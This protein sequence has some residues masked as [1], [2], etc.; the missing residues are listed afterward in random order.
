MPLN[1]RSIHPDLLEARKLAYEPCAFTFNNLSWEAESLEYGACAF[2]LN[3]RHVMFRS[4][5]KTP[6][7][8]GQ[9]VT[10]WKRPVIGGPILP[11]DV[12]DPVDLFVISVRASEKF[13]QFVFPKKVLLEKGIISK[14]EKGGKRAMRVYPPWDITDSKQ[15]QKTQSWQTLYFFEIGP[16]GHVDLTHVQKLF[17]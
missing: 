11:Y 1:S 5:K 17:L 4:A 15:A 16:N 3:D 7:K 6:K 12:D 9:F 14:E 8:V 10:L 13:G 2:D